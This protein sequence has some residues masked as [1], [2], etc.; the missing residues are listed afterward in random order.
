MKQL[1][2]LSLLGVDIDLDILPIWIIHYKKFKCDSYFCF[3]HAKDNQDDNYLKAKYLLENNGFKT[4]FVGGPFGDGN[5]RNN[6]FN[7][8]LQNLNPQDYV[9]TADTDEFQDWWEPEGV[10]EMLI[11]NNIDFIT[12]KLYDCFGEKLED[13]KSY[14]LIQQYPYIIDN[15]EN[16]INVEGVPIRRDKICISK[17]WVPVCYIGSHDLNYHFLPPEKRGMFRVRGDIRVLHFKWRGS[18]KKRLE[19][20]TYYKDHH[21]KK[22]LEYFNE[23]KLCQDL[24]KL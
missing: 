9:M 11:E 15:L 10:K 24:T 22:I 14:D 20:K 6:I 5:L 13:V 23:D 4:Q 18:L 7:A 1:H 2:F 17:V 19:S 8:Y 16:V 12:G 3:L 21:V